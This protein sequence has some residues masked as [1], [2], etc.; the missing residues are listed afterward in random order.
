M[1]RILLLFVIVLSLFT[2]ITNA[3]VS[4]TSLPNE[5]E[6][7][8]NFLKAYMP[9][10]DIADYDESFFIQQVEYA[11]KARDYFTWGK[12]IPEDIFQH[13]VLVYRVNNEN[14][15]S[16][17]VVF[18]NELKDRIKGMSMYDAAL[19]VNHWCHE[20][21]NYKAADGRTSAP[22]STVRTSHGRCGEESTFT[23]TALR[24]V[25]IPARQCYT[26]RWAHTDD[27]HAWVEVWIDGKWYYL[28][29]CEPEAELNFAWFD[30]PVK[31]AMM[32]HTTVFGAG[33]KGEEEINYQT[34]LYSR[35]NLLSNYAPTK[36]IYVKVTDKNNAVVDASVDFG[37]YNYAEY[38]P[39]VE[40]KTDENGLTFLTTGLGDLMI[41]AN[42]GNNYAYKKIS[43]K[44]TDTIYLTLMPNMNREY[45]E[46]LE[47]VPP[48][49]RAIETISEQKAQQN[50]KRLL[51]EDSIR[52]VYI[53]TFPNDKR[54]KGLIS[55]LVNFDSL[56]IA[57]AIKN[58]WGNYKAIEDFL[59]ENKNIPEAITILKLI[60]EK[61]L[62]DTPKEILQSHLNT[63][64]KNKNPKNYSKE[65]LENYVLNPR[66][67]LELITPWREYIYNNKEEIFG[68]TEI[69]SASQIATWVKEN[70]E[71][72]QTE[73]YYNCQIS[74]QGVLSMKQADK[75]SREILFVALARTLGFA[76]KYDWATANS[77][78]YE[79]GEWKTALQSKETN[80][81]NNKA[82]LNVHNYAAT[83]KIKPEYYSHFT[84]A[85]FIDGKF[86][87][88][89]YEYDPK[90]KEFPEKLIL[91]AG[92][93]RL[94]TGNRANDG[95]VY[96]K[97]NYFE[98][99]PNT[100]SDIFVQLREIPQ[101]LKVEGQMNMKTS[102]K[103]ENK[104]STSLS[105]LT[106]SKGL[107]L[108]I[109]DPQKEPTRHVMADIP[110]LKK[111]FEQWQGGLLFLV[112]D[113][114]LTSDFSQKN[115]KN[116]PEQSIFAIDKN[117]KIL[118]RVEKAL[119]KDFKDNFPIL[120]L[121][122]TKGE[123]VFL[124][125]GYRIGAGENLIKTI[126]QLEN[127]K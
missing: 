73:N 29:A 107:V 62:R 65:I 19:E 28:G 126:Y 22:L 51:Y 61:D 75:V 11:F 122:T 48:I 43:V 117:R 84:I 78:Y 79:D 58:S 127:P 31:R 77:Q 125:E 92:Y 85:K 20:Y 94:L 9:L 64:L 113:D 7:A 10:S 56:D 6:E 4:K 23:V 45:E 82:V 47:I 32:V 15:D 21:V 105:Q 103:I 3:Q 102:V 123:I 30:A 109:L 118:K 8:L 36:K 110:L 49:P 112:P 83:N 46:L 95:T 91:D 14:L 104:T 86:V 27:N 101:T 13:F 42:K 1:K 26:P 89:D 50:A 74:P 108:A 44:E 35:I 41:W 71:L 98:L 80:Q 87:T 124:S 66:I 96:V 72:N 25:S 88:L 59:R 40:K 67:Q 119:N 70:I 69:T 38:Y 114:K 52:N 76:A 17:R 63:F 12:T 34:D 68:E 99:K 16:A 81:Q 33:Y 115:Y 111:E 90:F 121:I 93:Y 57:N 100:S 39:L 120:L 106:N 37:L 2:P 116:L 54:I 24:S 53:S 18:F 5:Q 97:T 60:Y 55:E